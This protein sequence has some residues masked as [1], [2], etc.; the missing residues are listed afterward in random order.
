[1]MKHTS[2]TILTS[3]NPSLSESTMKFPKAQQLSE[4]GCSDPVR[5]YVRGS[6]SKSTRR[7]PAS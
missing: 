4:I 5:N 7:A 2:N 1:M 6:V 3:D